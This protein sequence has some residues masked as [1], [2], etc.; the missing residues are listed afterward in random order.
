MNIGMNLGMNSGGFS[1]IDSNLTGV[2]GADSQSLAAILGQN[3]GPSGVFGNN[4]VFQSMI[5]KMLAQLAE[6]GNVQQSSGKADIGDLFAGSDPLTAMETGSGESTDLNSIISSL[7]LKNGSLAKGLAL[8]NQKGSSL[9]GSDAISQQNGNSPKADVSEEEA[10]Q[11]LDVNAILA[12][13]VQGTG[14]HFGRNIIPSS[15]MNQKN[16]ADLTTINQINAVTVSDL[17]NNLQS[18]TEI[19][20]GKQTEAVASLLDAIVNHG[21]G[22]TTGNE[23]VLTDQEKELITKLQASTGKSG[24][25]SEAGNQQNIEASSDHSR[26]QTL[27]EK[28]IKESEPFEKVFENSIGYQ[29]Q[30]QNVGGSDAAANANL[31]TPSAEKTEAY[32]QISQ[33]I[34]TKLE[35]KG[36][37]EFKL[38]LE[39]ED[40]GQIDIK[41]KLQDGKLMIDILSASAKTHNLLTSQVDKLIMN[42]GLQNV[43]VE[44]VQVNQQMNDQSQGNLNQS[45]SMNSGMNFSQR[46][47]Q[48]QFQE[49][50]KSHGQSVISDGLK[51]SE[52]QSIGTSD[53]IGQLRNLTRRLDYAV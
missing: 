14:I 12:G 33:E 43:Q 53:S 49:Q 18:T 28:M 6:P 26:F 16:A 35:Q 42:M 32:S 4:S 37:M 38:Q 23:N 2:A 25:V 9:S 24:A 30:V 27:Q 36:P 50:L 45:F 11:N 31:Q 1:G 3:S 46:R 52:T 5:T 41:L 22:V 7:L 19:P 51:V 34:L 10:R 47:Q 44:N 15:E 8:V 29:S 21:E 17:T 40:L 20:A 48:E 13:L 39:P